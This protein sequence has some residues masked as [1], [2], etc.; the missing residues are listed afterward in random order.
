MV[1]LSQI[2]SFPKVVKETILQTPEDELVDVLATINSVQ[3]QIGRLKLEA[4][5][6]IEPDT[7][8][9]EWV[10]TQPMKGVRSYN[11]NGMLVALMKAL[12]MDL[13]PLI[14]FLIDG[15]VLRLS[16][17]YSNLLKVVRREN[18]VLRTAQ[19]EIKNGDPDYDMGEYWIHGSAGY[20]RKENDD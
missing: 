5:S 3:S 17:Q 1:D 11:D 19:W 4:A 15:D 8:G 7:S 12:N 18:I 16:W 6:E 14:A 2:Q 10:Y 9:N 13:V 20:V